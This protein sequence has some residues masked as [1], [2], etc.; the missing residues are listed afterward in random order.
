MDAEKEA[1]QN[2]K[3]EV[4]SQGAARLTIILQSTRQKQE[5]VA[6]TEEQVLHEDAFFLRKV[7]NDH[8]IVLFYEEVDDGHED[9]VYEIVPNLEVEDREGDD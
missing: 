6:I 9:D 2:R 7:D 5:P 3:N 1:L 8:D 4:S